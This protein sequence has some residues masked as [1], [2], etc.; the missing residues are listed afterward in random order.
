[1]TAFFIFGAQNV[2]S[3]SGFQPSAAFH[4]ITII[5]NINITIMLVIV[6]NNCEKSLVIV[7]HPFI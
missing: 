7:K 2:F 6:N 1:M 5:G 3:V 4:A